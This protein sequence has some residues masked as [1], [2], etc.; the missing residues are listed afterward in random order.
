MAKNI[1][2][3]KEVGEFGGNLL[4]EDDHSYW[5]PPCWN[6]KKRHFFFG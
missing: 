6:I 2:F 1:D 4:S 3:G 5:A